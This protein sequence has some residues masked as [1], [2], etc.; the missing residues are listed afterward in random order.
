MLADHSEI[1]RSVK[2]TVPTDKRSFVNSLASK[3]EEVAT[4]GNRYKI[5]KVICGKHKTSPNIPMQE[6][7]NIRKRTRNTMGRTP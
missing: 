5:T 4:K 7:L 1:D 3:A 6:T 2:R